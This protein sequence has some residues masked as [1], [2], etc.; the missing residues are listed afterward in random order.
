MKID[1]T[2]VLEELRKQKTKGED[3]VATSFNLG[4]TIA[5][6]I[7]EGEEKLEVLRGGK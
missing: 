2:K 4:I 3:M 5:I 6:I 7:V 1:S